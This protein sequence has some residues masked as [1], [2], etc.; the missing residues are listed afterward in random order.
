MKKYLV[1]RNVVVDKPDRSDRYVAGQVVELSAKEAK[2]LNAK[3][4][5][6]FLEAATYDQP[7]EESL[8]LGGE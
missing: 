5:A 2:A 8:E 4:S 7:L 6:P 3:A 1:L